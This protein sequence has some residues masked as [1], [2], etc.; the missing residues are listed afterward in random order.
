MLFLAYIP[1]LNPLELAIYQYIRDNLSKVCF[2]R[3]RDLANETH[4]STTTILR[5]CRKFECEG[6]SEF[7]IKLNLYKDQQKQ[8]FISQIDETALI[9]F[10]TRATE[11]GLTE[12]INEA[13]TILKDK[14]LVLFLGVGSSNIIA[15]YGS[16]YF[17]SIFRMA[18]RI[19]DPTNYPINFMSQEL[20]KR[21]CIVVLSVSGE[22][23]E[24]IDYLTHINMCDSMIISITNSSNSTIA[25]LSHVN[26]AYYINQESSHGADITSQLPALYILERIAKEM[27]AT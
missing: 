12:K 8:S 4:T 20:A 26:I 17:S 11:S 23:K 22:T 21:T 15:E 24:I 9:N 19:E 2:M 27:K 3:I 5:F 16:L 10:L 13:V 14:E 7:R 18:L 1:E 6:Y 25:K